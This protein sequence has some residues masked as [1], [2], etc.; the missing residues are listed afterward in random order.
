MTA[1]V[2]T[3]NLESLGKLPTLR[4]VD[5]TI[6]QNIDQIT[7]P[8]MTALTTD[9]ILTVP[10]VRITLVETIEQ[11]IVQ[12]IPANLLDL[13]VVEALEGLMDPHVQ[14]VSRFGLRI[15][16][17]RFPKLSFHSSFRMYFI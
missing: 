6:V 16:I 5:E 12:T 3:E 4:P 9:R 2:G 8:G 11:R 10:S 7:Q 15:Y 17:S 14:E 1:S 13:G